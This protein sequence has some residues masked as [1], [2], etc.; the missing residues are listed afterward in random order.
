[1]AIHPLMTE[2]LQ[3][4]SI[5]NSLLVNITCKLHMVANMIVPIT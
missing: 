3:D 5:E 4:Y 1:M 2:H